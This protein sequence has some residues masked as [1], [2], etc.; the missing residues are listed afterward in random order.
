M[1]AQVILSILLAC[2]LVYAWAQYRRSPLVAAA[3]M[4]TG[5]AGLY[6]VW[7]PEQST[8]VAEFIGI[9]RG[10]DLVLYLWV[11][12]SLIILLSLH[13]KLRIQHETL[14]R[15][16]R[17]MALQNVVAADHDLPAVI[18]DDAVRTA[19]GLPA[20]EHRSRQMGGQTA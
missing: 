10:A 3:S 12:I 15:L 2:V 19:P 8:V 6:L 13:L 17:A 7:A 14:T 5:I 1:I 9:G 16:A 18:T 20:P 11:C 4:A